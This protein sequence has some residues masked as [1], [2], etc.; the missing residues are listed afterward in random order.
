MAIQAV[1]ASSPQ[2]VI[3]YHY[4]NLR[5]GWNSNESTLTPSNVKS[6]FNLLHTVTL[7]EQVDAQPLVVPNQP[8]TAGP[9]PG[10]YEVVYVATENNTIYAIDAASGTILLTRSLGKPV[11]K[12]LGC[13][14]NSVV[15]GITSTPVID[16]TQKVM[17]LI[18]YVAVVSG[19]T[20]V[21][22]YFVHE[23]NLNDLTDKVTAVKV[24]A[25][26]T[27]TNGTTYTFNATNERQRPGLLEANGYIYA[28]FGSFCDF[29]NSVTRGWVLG[30]K[31]GTLATLSPNKLNDTQVA[32]QSTY[33]LASVWMAGYGLASDSTG[34]I[35]FATGNSDNAHDVWDGVTDIQESVVRLSPSNL[36]TIVNIFAPTDEFARDQHDL[37]LGAGGVLLLPT[38]PGSTP[39][40]AVIAGKHG[41][42]GPVLFL[43]D[44]ATMTGKG[45]G[46]LAQL[47]LGNC[48][49][50]QSYFNDGTPHVVSSTGTAVHLLNLKTGTSPTLTNVASAAVD[51]GQ[52]PGFFTSISSLGSANAII[53]AASR[54]H[55]TSVNPSPVIK[56]YAFNA[57]PSGGSLPLLFLN[58]NAGPWPHT[59]ADANTVPVVANGQ[60]FVA[61]YKQL[62]IFGLGTGIPGLAPAAIAPNVPSNPSEHEIFG[63]ITRVSGSEFTLRTRTGSLVE[64]DASAAIENELSIELEAGETVDVQGTLDASGVLVASS[65]QRAKASPALWP[66]DV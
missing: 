9:H 63:A 24:A 14:N 60:V 17:Y 26:H 29:K 36:N 8:I 62:S 33:Y 40:L 47:N 61:S 35:Y 12:P 43:L 58:T 42:N 53:W 39:P 22:T 3:T 6:S 57:T 44:R 52:D 21:P 4:D 49:C 15:V 51:S 41:S 16:F 31:T 34:D 55:P 18:S 28:G 10:T 2:A 50:G 27:L 30:W 46:I 54:P 11:A 20:T 19:S 23:L 1:N 7:D 13:A 32:P 45:K 25:S 5:T 65:V 37:D 64:V 56:L 38:Q 48:L 59:S 66:P